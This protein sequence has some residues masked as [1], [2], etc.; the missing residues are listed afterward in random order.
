M[1][2]AAP[3]FRATATLLNQSRAD[4]PLAFADRSILSRAWNFRLYDAEGILVW[5]SEPEDED[6]ENPSPHTFLLRPGRALSRSVTIPLWLE[7]GPLAPG[8]YTVEALLLADTPLVVTSFL[9]VLPG[10]RPP[11]PVGT[12]KG[13]VVHGERDSESGQMRPAPGMRVTIA[14][15]GPVLVSPDPNPP[16]PI[17]VPMAAGTNGAA[18]PG[19]TGNLVEA[20]KPQPPTVPP[21]Q[22]GWSGFTD[23]NGAFTADLLPGDYVVTAT[24]AYTI[25][26]YPPPPVLTG[27][28]EITI[29]A[30]ETTETTVVL[31][32][33]AGPP[34][35]VR[36]ANE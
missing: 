24:A 28:A 21:G 27:R 3:A 17:V 12:V 1:R 30:G 33:P 32:R 29:R 15:R 16:G 18:S 25:L 6:A 36:P 34:S 11:A 23:E 31:A 4:V 22:K 14:P 9:S 35:P 20:P 26:V 5:Q 19:S 10:K 13:L 7:D 8:R 2:L